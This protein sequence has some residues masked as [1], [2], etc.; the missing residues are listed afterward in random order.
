VKKHCG[1]CYNLV[2]GRC[3]EGHDKAPTNCPDWHQ[4]TITGKINKKGVK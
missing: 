4:E 1:N 3:L 2:N